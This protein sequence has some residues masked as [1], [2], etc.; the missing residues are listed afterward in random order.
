MFTQTDL[1]ACVFV[2]KGFICQME[3]FDWLPILR[4]LRDDTKNDKIGRVFTWENSHRRASHTGVTFWIRIAFTW[5]LGNFISRYLK[6]HFM[7]IKYTCDSKSQTLRMRYSFQS[8]GRPISH[9][10]GWTFRVYMIP[11]RNL[12]PEWNSRP[13]VTTGV[14]SRRGDSRRHD[15]LWWYHVNKFRAMR[16]NRS[17]LAPT[18]KSPRCHVKHPL[19]FTL[20]RSLKIPYQR[21]HMEK[22]YRQLVTG[23]SSSRFKLAVMRMDALS[24]PMNT[25]K[26]IKLRNV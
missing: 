18:R 21:G 15:I 20:G 13:G 19:V 3:C 6:V 10:N 2:L 12:V 4:S 16:G 23:E 1:R 8:T 7:L 17:E 9:P 5:W 26:V 22:I 25:M 14:N 24:S 11:L